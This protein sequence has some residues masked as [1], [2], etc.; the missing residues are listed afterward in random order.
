MGVSSSLSSSSSNHNSIMRKLSRSGE[1][2][3]I[4]FL[5]EDDLSDKIIEIKRIKIPFFD[6]KHLQA[7]SNVV[8]VTG[9]S[10][11]HEGLIF[12]TK[13]NQYYITQTYPITFHKVFSFKDGIE[14]I[15]GFCASNRDTKKYEIRDIWVSKRDFY[16]KDI[17]NV[18]KKLP[19]KYDIINENCQTY[20]NS[21]LNQLPVKKVHSTDNFNY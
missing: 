20:C 1:P 8:Y 4:D 3:D 11:F 13:Q 17:I 21:I 10:P 6:N 19:N 5:D 7:L 12:E 2:L 15:K 16:V 9:N 14:R 18:I